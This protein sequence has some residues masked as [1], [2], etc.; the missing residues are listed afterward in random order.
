MKLLTLFFSFLKKSQKKHLSFCPFCLTPQILTV[1]SATC[2]SCSKTL[3]T[4]FF[5]IPLQLISFYGPPS[6]ISYESILLRIFSSGSLVEKK[7]DLRL[8]SEKNSFL[9]TLFSLKKRGPKPLCYI[10]F[11]KDQNLTLAPF[12]SAFF[13]TLRDQNDSLSHFENLTETLLKNSSSFNP[14]L[15]RP[16]FILN[17]SP[18]EEILLNVPEFLVGILEKNYL[19]PVSAFSNYIRSTIALWFG[20]RFLKLLENLFPKI[21]YTSFR[22]SKENLTPSSLIEAP[23]LWIL[24]NW[25]Y[26]PPPKKRVFLK[27][28]FLQ[29]IPSLKKS[30][31][32]AI[33]FKAPPTFKKI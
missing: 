17:L 19:S 3:P 2:F 12:T 14:F 26:C 23:F 18:L 27:T 15:K 20:R 5:K 29:K 16:L 32:P 13:Y 7:L 4:P 31:P 11:T 10:R 22:T 1:K 6:E 9:Y 33:K 25:G 8:F 24:Q 21:F 30:L 28:F